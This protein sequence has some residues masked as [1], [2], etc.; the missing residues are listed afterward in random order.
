M[1]KISVVPDS[2]IKKKIL[3]VFQHSGFL[4]LYQQ[5]L[6][7]EYGHLLVE[8]APATGAGKPE[9]SESDKERIINNMKLVESLL[10]KTTRLKELNK[11]IKSQGK[12]TDDGF[13]PQER[14]AV[15]NEQKKLEGEIK[16]IFQVKKERGQQTGFFYNALLKQ[17]S[18]TYFPKAGTQFELK[19]DEELE[20]LQNALQEELEQEL[21]QS[22]YILAIREKI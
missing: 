22:N 14:L 10:E 9:I 11:K 16:E 3:E 19:S 17:I 12:G 20:A 13:T 8:N 21:N 4:S 15:V 7:D 18:E 6:L 5:K 1:N 2:D